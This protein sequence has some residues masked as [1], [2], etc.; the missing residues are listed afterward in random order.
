MEN[1]DINRNLY[2]TITFSCNKTRTKTFFIQN[3]IIEN[4]PYLNTL[5]YPTDRRLFLF[6]IRNLL[7]YMKFIF[8]NSGIEEK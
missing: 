5:I 8:P 6:E 2:V 1:P 4:F 7:Y 3:K